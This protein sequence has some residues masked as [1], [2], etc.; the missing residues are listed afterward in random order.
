MGRRKS[1]F[2]MEPTY[3]VILGNAH[4]FKLP[5]GRY[6]GLFGQLQREE[7]DM[8]F[9]PYPLNEIVMGDFH[10]VPVFRFDP[11]SIMSGVRR[12]YVDDDFAIL[13]TFEPNVWLA[14]FVSWIAV[15][16]V[17]MLLHGCRVPHATLSRVQPTFISQ[18]FSYLQVLLMEGE[19]RSHNRAQ[20]LTGYTC[21]FRRTRARRVAQRYHNVL[22]NDVQEFIG[23]V[24]KSDIEEE[25]REECPLKA[26]P[27][28]DLEEVRL[29]PC[30]SMDL[31]RGSIRLVFLGWM[32]GS[33]L[34]GNLVSGTVKGSLV[35]QTPSK[36]INSVADVMRLQPPPTP[37][38]L[39]TEFLEK[40]LQESPRAEFRAM[41]SLMVRRGGFLLDY[42]DMVSGRTFDALMAGTGVQISTEVAILEHH[43]AACSSPGRRFHIAREPILEMMLSWYSSRATLAPCFLR[44]MER[45]TMWLV[46]SGVQFY[47]RER[48]LSQIRSCVLRE[49]SARSKVQEHA[50]LSL[51][52]VKA[53]FYLSLALVAAA[54]VAFVGEL[55]SCAQFRRGSLVTAA[56]AGEP[57][58][59][60]R[61]PGRS[62]IGRQCPRSARRGVAMRGRVAPHAVSAD[63][64][65]CERP[66]VP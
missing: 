48:W 21:T 5:N 56:A 50:A 24:K 23:S 38:T 59:L 27:A 19:L 51:R 57:W 12:L 16:A 26:A 42:M 40:A 47:R 28:T 1:S 32:L 9:F 15:T 62:S 4:G 3:S 49:A 8:L 6:D 14:I 10:A 52:D 25:R 33:V 54:P 31:E 41:H 13:T 2:R 37:Y 66:N 17:T 63:I 7:V 18:L 11:V 65:Q 44:R 34:L 60:P 61:G 39:K 30:T 58:P 46:E 22:L 43:R 29:K 36:R 35:V 55:L 53:A 20:C 45:K 64:W